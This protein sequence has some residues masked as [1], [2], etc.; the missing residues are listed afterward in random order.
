M[1]YSCSAIF[2]VCAGQWFGNTAGGDFAAHVVTVYR[3]EVAITLKGY[4]SPIKV[5]F[6]YPELRL[7]LQDIAG[8]ILAVAQTG[9]RGVCVL[10]ANGS[11]SNVTIRQPASSGGLLTYE[12]CIRL[13]S[14]LISYLFEYECRSVK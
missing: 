8:K 6:F 2:V 4:L 9:S 12:V 10:S 7:Q 5:V 11:V 13:S 1:I 14:Y 3:G